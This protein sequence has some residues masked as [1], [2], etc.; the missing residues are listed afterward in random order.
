MQV[1]I[2]G[3]YSGKQPI[4]QNRGIYT[5]FPNVEYGVTYRVYVKNSNTADSFFK[6]EIDVLDKTLINRCLKNL[7]KIEVILWRL[8]KQI[9]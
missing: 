1:N 5:Y 2:Y 9:L 7:P 8:K 4:P 6:L 3:K